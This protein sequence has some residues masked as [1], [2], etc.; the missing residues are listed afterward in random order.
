[1]YEAYTRSIFGQI[2]PFRSPT[3][4]F[5]TVPRSRTA[6]QSVVPIVPSQALRRSSATPQVIDLDTDANVLPLSS[7]NGR[8]HL[9]H[10]SHWTR[11]GRFCAVIFGETATQIVLSGSFAFQYVT[12]STTKLR[13]LPPMRQH[14]SCSLLPCQS[15]NQALHCSS[16]VPKS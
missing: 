16:A 4:S 14:P 3:I 2:P 10:R 7:R 12:P 9:S 1:M 11:Q 15:S 6:N 8:Y 5:A 13:V